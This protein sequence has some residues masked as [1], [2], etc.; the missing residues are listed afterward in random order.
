MITQQINCETHETHKRA[1]QLI[2]MIVDCRLMKDYRKLVDRDAVIQDAYLASYDLIESHCGSDFNIFRARISAIASR[3]TS[4]AMRY[5]YAQRR[6]GLKTM[7]SLMSQSGSSYAELFGLSAGSRSPSGYMSSKEV[8]AILEAAIAELSDTER[9]IAKLHWVE[10]Y[11]HRQ[12]AHLLSK[13]TNTV[14]TL[15][16]RMRKKL[17]ERV[18]RALGLFS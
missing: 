2:R 5:A 13:N 16:H 3:V 18:A 14:N 4:K 1:F 10:G 12:I 17:R 7:V 9:Q 6:G 11:E 15:I 8:R